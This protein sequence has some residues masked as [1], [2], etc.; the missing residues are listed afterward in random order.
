[1]MVIDAA[2]SDFKK[3]RK[4]RKLSAEEAGRMFGV[5]GVQWSRIENGTR[6]VAPER[7]LD[8]ERET[9]VSRHKIRPDIFGPATPPKHGE[10]A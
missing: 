8:V 9:G 1:M 4:G 7:V 6:A 3:W 5:S 10:A 2:M